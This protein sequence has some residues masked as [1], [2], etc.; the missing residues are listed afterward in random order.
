MKKTII[1]S[2]SGIS[3]ASCVAAIESGLRSFRGVVSANVNFASE[4]ATV[5]YDP[6]IT[7]VLKIEKV[8]EATGY[9]VVRGEEQGR[10]LYENEEKIKKED[11]KSLKLKFILSLFFTI[12]LFYY[13][14]HHLFSFP[15]S[16][17]FMDN[18]VV[19]QFL[20]TT[21]VVFIGG[22]FFKR[23]IFSLFKTKTANM[24]T[25]VSLG[26]GS[27]YFYSVFLS[28]LILLGNKNLSVN[29][30]Y[31]EVSA[32]LITFILLGKYFES[33]AKG[34]TSQ[35]IK[36]LLGLKPKTA[37]VLRDSKEI[38]IPVDAVAIGDIV[39]VKP[40]QK[41]PV[42]GVVV[43]GDSFV[44]ESMVTGESMP[45]SKKSGDTVVGGTINVS[46]AFRFKALKV[47]K[48][49]FLYQ[50]I[51]MV[52]EAQGSKAPVQEL[53]DKISSYFVPFVLIVALLSSL[54]WLLSGSGVSFALTVFISV[55]V[56]ACPCALGLATP[57]AIMVGTGLGAEKGI[58]IKNAK[59]LQIASKINVMFFDKT[60]TLTKGHPQVVDI[61]PAQ[62][63]SSD[64]LLFFSSIAEKMSEHPI[65]KA[66]IMRAGKNIPDPESFLSFPGKGIKAS[67][68]G[69]DLIV[70]NYGFIAESGVENSEFL[71]KAHIF[72]AQGNTVVFCSKGINL[73][74]F[75]VV[76]DE[77]KQSSKDAIKEIKNMGIKTVMIT[78]D[79]EKTAQSIA[80]KVG[81]DEV[82]AKVLPQEKAFK[83]K[84]EQAKGNI[85]SM[86]GDGINDAPALAQSDIGIA[87]GS[88]TD[89]AIES[90]DIVIVGDSLSLAAKA[91]KLS[92]F[93]M[94]K[95]RQ[96]LFWAFIYNLLG[97]PIAAGI[98]YP[99]TGVLLNPAIAGFA[100]S[101]SSVSV[102]SNSLMMK[103]F[104]F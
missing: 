4:K 57:T 61:I 36:K 68:K 89:V 64:D 92:S 76:A 17:F 49:T 102:V 67:Y 32:F 84:E 27:A 14:L 29:D 59:S 80:V 101:L 60:G 23:G 10:G 90:G 30:L 7:D 28:V 11:V 16:G 77:E 5:I 26:V 74:G 63:F 33:V 55:L 91:V 97:I 86:V 83:I 46:G 58:L 62:G 104:K 50:I 39:I 18:G 66:I 20:L 2:I 47:G 35:A 103:R 1:I 6:E 9:T 56:I 73:L 43:D 41:I 34:E 48:D 81:I 15:M 25:L 8:I 24:D 31:F 93:T 85:V 70:G 53:A 22:I 69:E 82:V 38:L 21:P 54:F 87:I 98:L 12:P 99:F 40:G 79:N 78:G 13:M 42:D 100:M 45:V 72:E 94:L 51:K 65:S 95:I 96:N 44:D 3:C 19:I 37:S 88:G 71:A 52:E 75:I